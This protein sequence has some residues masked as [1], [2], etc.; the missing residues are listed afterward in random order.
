MSTDCFVIFKGENDNIIVY[1]TKI[2]MSI[3]YECLQKLHNILSNYT[4]IVITR[5]LQ[6]LYF[7]WSLVHKQHFH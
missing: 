2:N 7:I 1:S 5:I 4:C 3:E 6:H